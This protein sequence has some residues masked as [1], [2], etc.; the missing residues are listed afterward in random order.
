MVMLLWR[1]VAAF[2]AGTSVVPDDRD[3]EAHLVVTDR[4]R[5]WG[6]SA[7]QR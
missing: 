3:L 4:V 2:L 1:L 6:R 7:W 5:A